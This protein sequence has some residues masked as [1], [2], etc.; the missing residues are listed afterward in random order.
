MLSRFSQELKERVEQDLYRMRRIIHSAPGAVIRWQDRE[1]INFSSNDYLNLAEDPAVA[2]AAAQTASEFG[3]GAGASALISGYLKPHYELEKEIAQWEGTESALVFSSG[4]ATNV[5]VIS[6]LVSKED[7]IFSDQLNHASLIDGCRL[8]RGTVHIYRHNDMEHLHELLTEHGRPGASWIVTDTIFSMDGD[9]A[10][11][12]TLLKFADEFDCLLILDEAHATGVIGN[13]GRGLTE[14]YP[15][16]M[17]RYGKQRVIKVGTMSKALGTQGG[18]VCA[19]ATISDYLIN[20]AR[21]YIFST[22]LSPLIVGAT[23]KAIEIVQQQPERR[24]RLDQLS[25]WLSVE[26]HRQGWNIGTSSSQ[27]IPIIIGESQKAL[28]LSYQL[29]EAGLLVPAIRPP[30]VPEGTSRLRLSL[31]SAHTEEQLSKLLDVLKTAS[32]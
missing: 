28:D 24:Q 31:T 3:C 8:S 26:L 30:S 5:A 22:S 25:Q 14:L 12:E 2:E 21:P 18:F 13:Q 16:A 20:F 6:S 7:V 1:L 17:Q 15:I 4:F 10:E 32:V 19:P 11:L 9:R 29:Q 23:R 27:I